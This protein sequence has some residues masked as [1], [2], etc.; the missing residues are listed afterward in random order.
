MYET[1]LLKFNDDL[2]ERSRFLFTPHPYDDQTIGQYIDR[3]V[4]NQDLMLVAVADDRIIAYFFL[5]Y[6]D[7]EFPVLGI[8]IVEDYQGQGL[9]RQIMELLIQEAKAA[10]CSAVELT[11]ALDNKT[12]FAL[13]EK[14]G[15][16]C[17][18][19]VNNVS[20][21]GRIIKEWHLYYPIKPDVTPPPREHRAPI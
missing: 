13:Y 11:T 19:Q 20:G 21:D 6:Y 14:T 5:W 1:A 4:N 8:G 12:A 9:G 3:T 10:G 2:S 17:L 15:F 16:K 18:G 7:T